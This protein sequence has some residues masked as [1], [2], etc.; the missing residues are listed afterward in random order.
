VIADFTFFS[1]MKKG[2]VV[3]LRKPRKSTAPDLD[4]KTAN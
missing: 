2:A 3:I 4:V 1:P